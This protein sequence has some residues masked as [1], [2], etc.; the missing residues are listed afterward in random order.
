MISR[1]PPQKLAEFG[2]LPRTYRVVDS[3]RGGGKLSSFGELHSM[4]PFLSSLLPVFS[5][6]FERLFPD[7]VERDKANLEMMK[8]I[9]EMDAK[10]IESK[11][12]VVLAEAQGSWLQRNWRPSMMV[13]FAGLIVS[14]WFGWS[15]NGLTQETINHLFTLLEIGIGGYVVGRSAEKVAKIW[16][17][18]KTEILEDYKKNFSG[19]TKEHLDRIEKIL[20]KYEPRE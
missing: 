9:Q 20:D 8:V 12:S 3:K 5:K 1:N 6:I 19:V 10:I 14:Y 4:F 15:P 13:L 16:K 11:A 2:E 7:P 17:M 18:P